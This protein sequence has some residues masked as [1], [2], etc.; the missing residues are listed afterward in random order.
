ML[1]MSIGPRIMQVG[2][3]IYVAGLGLKPLG[4]EFKVRA[5]LLRI[6]MEFGVAQH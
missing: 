5:C 6:I 1:S 4:E 2:A 3:F